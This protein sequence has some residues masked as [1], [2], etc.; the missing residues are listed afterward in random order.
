M[1][2]ATAGS[3]ENC[4]E[5]P[6]ASSSYLPAQNDSLQCLTRRVALCGTINSELDVWNGSNASG[7]PDHGYFRSTPVNGHSQDRQACL[8]SA[9]SGLRAECRIEAFPRFR[10]AE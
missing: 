8:K 7:W 5:V 3:I 6:V 4:A 1:M 2:I 10:R 9:K